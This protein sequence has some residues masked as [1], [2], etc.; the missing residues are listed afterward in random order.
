MLARLDSTD[1]AVIAQVGRPWRSACVHSGLTW[2]GK[3]AGVPLKVKDF[4]G[5]VEWMAWAEAN[6]CRW[7]Q[8]MDKTCML[9]LEG[10]H[11]A[12]IPPSVAGAAATL[13]LHHHCCARAAKE[14][15]FPPPPS[16]AWWARRAQV[17]VGPVDACLR[18]WGRTAIGDAVTRVA[19][20][21]Q[22][23][24]RHKELGDVYRARCGVEQWWADNLT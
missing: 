7:D 17:H 1:I 18:C 5:S 8:W 4:G 3:S 16:V 15:H 9:V 23:L 24:Q 6:G 11:M 19:G 12:M 21:L 2:A 10:G 20:P 13:T 14:G 22:T